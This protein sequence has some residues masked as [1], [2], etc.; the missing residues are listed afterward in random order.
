MFLLFDDDYEKWHYF[1]NFISKH[2]NCTEFSLSPFDGSR[3]RL[4]AAQQGLAAGRDNNPTVLI[5]QP[6]P[7]FRLSISLIYLAY[8]F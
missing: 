5:S 8:A 1:L 6:A 2:N 3:P 7:I 4:G